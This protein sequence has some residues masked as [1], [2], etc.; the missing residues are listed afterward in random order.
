V[1]DV[2]GCTDSE[3]MP[4]L[5]EALDVPI[6]APMTGRVTAGADSEQVGAGTASEPKPSSAEAKPHV[7]VAVVSVEK[8]RR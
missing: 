3:C 4:S 7:A 6:C 1:F 8:K 5:A 2:P